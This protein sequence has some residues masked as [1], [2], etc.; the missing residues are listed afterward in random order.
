[1][2]TEAADANSARLSA[3]NPM[4]RLVAY[5][6]LMGPG[7]LQSAMTLGGGTAFASIFAGAAF[8]YQLLWVAPLSMLLGVIVLSAVAHQTLSTDMNPFQAMKQYAGPFFAYGWAIGAILSSIIWQ[9]AQYALAAAMMVLL[10]EQLGWPGAPRWLMGL[11]ALVWCILVGLLYFRTPK[12]VRTYEAILKWMVWFI[13]ACF[14]FVVINTGVPAPARLAAGFVPTLPADFV[15]R[16]GTLISAIVVMVSGLAAAVGVNMLFV[17]PYSLRRRGWDRRH[18]RLAGY[19][20]LFGTFVPFVIAASLM[21][22]ASASIFHFGDPTLFEGKTIPPSRVA[23]ILAAPDRLGPVV[24]VWVFGLGIIA[25]ALS[26]ITMQ[27]LSSGFACAEVFGWRRG[28]VGHTIGALLPAIGVLG[29]VFW[30]DIVMW[31]AVPTNVVCGFL[32]P[33][34]YVG[35]IRLQHSRAYLGDARPT[36]GRATLWMLGM[37]VATLVLVIGLAQVVVREGP[38]Y[39]ARIRD[40]VRPAPAIQPVDDAGHS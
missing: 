37:V 24:G 30:N 29:A 38:G 32:M 12:L 11:I 27:M 9:F 34:A 5:F 25:M 19:D 36:G 40:A 26:S 14:A 39:V 10:A 33:I 16:D 35:F 4:T 1:M 3:A 13:I 20:L 8:G 31:V 7:Y 18:R 6:H 17:Y 2:S 21:V 15:A 23:Q 22:I 28:T